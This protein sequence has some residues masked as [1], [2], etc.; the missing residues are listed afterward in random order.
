MLGK[1]KIEQL[2]SSEDIIDVETAFKK[3]KIEIYDEDIAVFLKTFPFLCIKY[4]VEINQ[5]EINIDFQEIDRIPENIKLFTNLKKLEARYNN[6][7]TIPSE[8]FSLINLTEINLQKNSI[9]SIPGEV[10]NLTKLESLILAKNDIKTVSNN[11]SNLPNLKILNLSHNKIK[12]GDFLIDGFDNLQQLVLNKNQLTSLPIEVQRLKSLTLLELEGNP[13][14][15][16][17]KKK[18][19]SLLPNTEVIF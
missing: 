12:S 10:N 6:F 3:C 14:Q 11:L 19:E 4:G 17:E 8:I 9:D 18:I 5:T 13:I 15:G 1:K 7:K 2:L 16:V